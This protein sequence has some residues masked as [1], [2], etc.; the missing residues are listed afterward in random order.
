MATAAEVQAE[1]AQVQS[2]IQQATQRESQLIQAVQEAK[3]RQRLRREVDAA[4]SALFF[5]EVGNTNLSGLRANID[6]DRSGP[7]LVG[8]AAD[9]NLQR[10]RVHELPLQTG[11]R[12][13]AHSEMNCKQAVSTGTFEWKI[14]GMSWLKET[15]DQA[16][17]PIAWSPECMTAGN[18]ELTAYYCPFPDVDIVS[19]NGE[20]CHVT[21]GGS[22]NILNLGRC[23]DD[24][25]V[26]RYR[27]YILHRDGHYVQWGEEG[28]VC[29]ANEDL[30]DLV[31]GPDVTST[32]QTASGVFGLQ[33]K[34]LLQSEWVNNDTLTVKIELEVRPTTRS[35]G[36]N[37][38]PRKQSIQVPEATISS[39]FLSLFEGERCTDITFNVK[40]ESIKAHS[41]V[42][43]ARSEVFQRQF[44]GGLQESVS[45]EVTIEDMEPKIFKGFLKFLYTDGL[46]HIEATIKKCLEENGTSS[47]STGSTGSVPS[48]TKASILQDILAM[49]HKYQELRLLAWCQ[50]QLCTYITEREVCSVLCQA[51]LCEAQQLEAA[52]LDYIKEHFS[53]IAPTEEFARLTT[54]W[55]ELML[56][57]SLHAQGVSSEETA[58][59][60]ST[61]QAVRKRKREA[62]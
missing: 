33:H 53:K 44:F 25:T 59:A 48:T 3:E 26:I 30:E 18:V 49:S 51:H 40:G 8:H 17:E 60:L 22:V 11:T 41:Q 55:P 54:E 13:Q 56:K 34:E 43:A 46:E 14:T 24:K 35:V 57:I 29:G 2:S 31:F 39:K 5:K 50:Q 28:Q 23:H 32:S 21:L 15:L 10:G 45:K 9:N 52:C 47:D 36:S 6:A 58:A 19:A 12:S 4:K 7:H 1:L 20:E 61:Q 27:F 16:D 38:P 37:L 42:L 62:S